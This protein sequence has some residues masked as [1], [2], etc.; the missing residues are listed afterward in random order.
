LSSIVKALGSLGPL[1]AT[2]G[3]QPEGARR[4][5]KLRLSPARRA[6]LKLQGQ[7]MGYVRGLKATQ[8][9]QVRKLKAAKGIQAAIRMAKNLANA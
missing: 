4:G 7:Y 8:K 2:A 1:L 5:R 3:A 6:A 9:A